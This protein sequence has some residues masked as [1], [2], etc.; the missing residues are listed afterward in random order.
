MAPRCSG[1]GCLDRPGPATLQ[2]FGEHARS[3]L[4]DDDHFF[5]SRAGLFKLMHTLA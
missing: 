5:G 1:S 3:P 4:E 2:P